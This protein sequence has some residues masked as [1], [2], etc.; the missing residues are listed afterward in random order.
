MVSKID[1]Y[2]ELQKE[3]ICCKAGCSSCCETGDY[4]ISEKEL[5]TLMIGYS[6]LDNESK[7]RVQNNL[8]KM[9]R[10]GACPFLLDSLCSVY[11]YRP[12]IC[13]IYGLAYITKNGVVKVPYCANEGKNYSQVYS[14]GEFFGEPIK[15]NLD[16][17]LGQ[18][19]NLYDWIN[20]Y[21]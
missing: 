18:T 19:R 16:E 11:E 14:N 17:L 6:K 20:D 8:K 5:K 9:V 15:E 2:F 13:R 1:K 12:T 7:I 3:F 4:P 21:Q 10:G